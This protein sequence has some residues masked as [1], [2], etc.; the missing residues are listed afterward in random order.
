MAGS[1]LFPLSWSLVHSLF[2]LLPCTAIFKM[3][4]NIM[5]VLYASSFIRQ[6]VSKPVQ[7]ER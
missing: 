5:Y 7:T 2:L 3:L 6:V 4:I 1:Y